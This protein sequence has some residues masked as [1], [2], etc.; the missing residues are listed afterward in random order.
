MDAGIRPKI[1]PKLELQDGIQATRLILPDCYFDESGTKDGLLALKSYHREYDEDRKAY[2]DQPVHD[3]SSHY[4]DAFR[5]LAVV[6]S[7]SVTTKTREQTLAEIAQASNGLYSFALQDLWDLQP[8][9]A[10]R[11]P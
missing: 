9:K 11:I 5:G 1:I 8:T 2:R 3:W 4:A 7:K 10:S 6:C